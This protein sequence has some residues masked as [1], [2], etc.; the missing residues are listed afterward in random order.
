MTPGEALAFV[1]RH[2]VVLQSAKG[3]VPRLAEIIAGEPV[4]GAWWAH[5]KGHQ[6]FSVCGAVTN[7]PDILACRL[8]GGKITYV[9][10]RLWPALIRAAGNFP[11]K[12]LSRVD[13][14][15]TVAG[16]H[17][18]RETPY[19]DWADSASLNGASAL[20]EDEALAALGPWAVVP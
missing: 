9:H 17:I 2:G 18:S 5:Q 20:S 6:M 16:H 14:G 13:Q 7:S 10:R 11:A 12:H 3:P 15:H 1:E 8:V 4:K 19:P